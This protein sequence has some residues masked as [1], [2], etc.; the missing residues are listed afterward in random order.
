MAWTTKSPFGEITG[1]PEVEGLIMAL[2]RQTRNILAILL[3]VVPVGTD[4]ITAKP[5]PPRENFVSK[6]MGIIN[7]TSNVMEAARGQKHTFVH[8]SERKLWHFNSTFGSSRIL[9]PKLKV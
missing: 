6:N 2:L 9:E 3:L 5:I 7:L 4:S 1:Y 8:C